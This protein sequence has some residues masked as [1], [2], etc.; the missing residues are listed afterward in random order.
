[1]KHRGTSWKKRLWGEFTLLR[2]FRSLVFVYATLLAAA[3]LLSDF[4]IFPYRASSY[5]EGLEAF[6]IDAADGARLALKEYPNPNAE[7]TLLY[8]HGNA[9]DLGHVDPVLEEY[10]Q[11]G[12]AVFAFDYRGYGKSTGRATA[13]NVERDAE[14][15]FRFL[16]EKRKVDPEKTVLYG[17][18]VGS[19]P[20]TFLALEHDCAALVL[21][22]AFVSAFRVRTRIALFPFDR[23]N[24][25]ER[26]KKVDEP[27]L[28]VH[29]K[30]DRIVPFWHAQKL[31]AAKRGS[32]ECLWV[33]EAGHNDLLIAAGHRYWNRLDRFVRETPASRAA[34]RRPVS[35]HRGPRVREEAK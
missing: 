20:A 19:G 27:L 23:F 14:T 35:N 8:F 22:S 17:R 3:V 24:N 29:G 15:V 33:E 25:L 12:F 28:I 34:G 5:D 30:K 6:F 31:Y 7:F 32:K 4:L 26:I 1:M 2:L 21:E 18:S 13:S 10:R 9:E 16:T 11:A